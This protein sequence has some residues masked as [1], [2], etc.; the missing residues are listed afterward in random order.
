M[1]RRLRR[2]SRRRARV[3]RGDRGTLFL[4]MFDLITG[5]WQL[6]LRFPMVILRIFD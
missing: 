1:G 5:L 4:E 3:S 2:R 6:L